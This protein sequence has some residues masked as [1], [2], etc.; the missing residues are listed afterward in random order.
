MKLYLTCLALNVAVI[1]APPN[2]KLSNSALEIA[3]AMAAGVAES[4]DGQ[5]PNPEYLQPADSL[6][7]AAIDSIA[8]QRGISL[9]APNG[10]AYCPWSKSSGQ[11]GYRVRITVDSVNAEQAVGSYLL[12]CT[13]PDL[14]G[15]F[16]TGGNAE[17]RRE[18]GR[19]II[20]KW[21]D[22]WIT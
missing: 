15:A 4:L 14:R 19:W 18:R 5:R 11:K 21:L 20:A 7:A 6:T 9:Q 10:P 17:L 13:G 2:G 8:K 22:R 1:T 3:R 12:S 16:M